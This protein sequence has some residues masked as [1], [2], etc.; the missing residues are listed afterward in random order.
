MSDIKQMNSYDID[1]RKPDLLTYSFPC[2]D[3]S[4]MNLTSNKGLNL[5]NGHVVL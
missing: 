2:Q 1:A 4:T 5:E 3:L